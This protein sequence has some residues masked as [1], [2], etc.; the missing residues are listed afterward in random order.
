MEENI[1]CKMDYSE[2]DSVKEWN[3]ENI[4]DEDLDYIYDDW[5]NREE[6]FYGKE[7]WKMRNVQ[8]Y[9]DTDYLIRETCH[10]KHNLLLDHVYGE[11][12][13]YKKFDDNFDDLHNYS[14]D[15][16]H[17]VTKALKH[18]NN[19]VTPIITTYVKLLL[20]YDKYNKLHILKD[21]TKLN[22]DIIFNIIIKY[23]P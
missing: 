16:S 13:I 15:E 14:I 19:R 8:A 7:I 11:N 21:K 23:M 9:E 20:T 18:V 1:S 10:V 22:N 17:N 5:E 12:R 6:I 3:L 2:L 4:S